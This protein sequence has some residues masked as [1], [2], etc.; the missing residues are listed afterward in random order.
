M[1]L[2]VALLIIIISLPHEHLHS[3]DLH[4]SNS[5]E[6]EYRRGLLVLSNLIF[7]V[8]VHHCAIEHLLE[9]AIVS[10]YLMGRVRQGCK[11]QEIEIRGPS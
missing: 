3:I 7:T 1:W 8:I 4:A 9:I 5:N 10:P 2:L 11:H 6:G